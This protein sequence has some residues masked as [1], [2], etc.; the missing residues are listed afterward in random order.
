MATI[1]ELKERTVTETPLLLFECHLSSGAKECWS[2]HPVSVD[3]SSYAARV[4]THNLF[5]MRASSDDGLDS[6]SRVSLTLANADSYFSQIAR[7][8]GLKG[9]R[10]KVTFAFYDLAAGTVS[11]ESRVLFQGV[12]NAPDE[13]TES[14]MR[15]TA[16][17]RFSLLRNFL[18]EVRIQKRCPWSFPTTAEMRQN[19][20][21]GGSRGKYSPLSRCGYSADQPNGVGNFEEGQPY[22]SCDFTRTQCEERGMF[23]RDSAGRTTARFGGVEFVPASILVRGYGEHGFHQSAPVEN[24]TRYND[25]VPLGYGTVWAETPVVFVR[26]DGNLTRMEVLLGMGEVSAVHK[27]LVDD[28]EVPEGVAGASMAHTGWFNLVSAGGASG[29][30]NLDFTD[31]GGRP[32]GDPY[33]SIAFLSVVVPN[34]ISDGR[35]IPTVHVLFDGL[36]VPMY[37]TQGAYVGEFFTNNPAWVLL[38]LLRRSGWTIQEV[39]PA[40]FAIAALHCAEP[41]ASTDLYGNPI[42]I[43]RYQCN[44]HVSRRRSAADLIRG[45]C[46]SAGLFLNYN[47]VGRLELRFE[48]D[49]QRQQPTPPE[50]TNGIEA[51]NGG[52]PAYEFGDGTSP[53]SGILRRGDGSSSV[54]LYHRSAAESVNRLSVEF[55]DEFNEYQQDSLSLIDLD[56]YH[57]TGQEVSGNLQA[58]GIPNFHQAAR[59]LRRQLNKSTRGS[60]FIE[61]ETSVKAIYLRPGDIIT[62]TYQKEGLLRQPFRVT[63][64]TPGVNFQTVRLT[65]QVHDDAWFT[66]DADTGSSVSR[67][68][69]GSVVGLP[70]PLV[71]TSIDENGRQQFDVE[72]EYME[73][74]DGNATLALKVHFQ[75]PSRSART[76]VAIPMLSLASDVDPGGGTLAGGQTLYYAVSGKDSAGNE[77]L[78]SFVVRARIPLGSSSNAV[79]LKN[80]RFSEGTSS[81]NVYRGN[82][83]SQ[84][85]LIAENVSLADQF[86]DAG[87]TE[88]LQGPPDPNFEYARFE[89]RLEQLPETQATISS[90]STIGN[91]DL[92]VAAN[93]FAG[94]IAKIISGR[95]AGQE[96]VIASHDN[97]TFQVVGD[98]SELPDVTS[99]FV[100]VEAAWRPG[101]TS[102]TSPA[103]FVALNRHGATIHVTGRAGNAHGREVGYEISPLTRWRIGGGS[104]GTRD[105]DVPPAPTFGLVATGQGTIEVTGLAFPVF[106]NTRTIQAGTL[107]LHFWDELAGSTAYHLPGTLDMT[108]E[109]VTLN[110][111]GTARPGDLIQMSNEVMEVREVT[112]DGLN[113]QVLRGA[114]DTLPRTH[115]PGAPIYHM[116]RKNYVMAFGRDFFGSPASG[117]YAYMVFLPD[118]RIAAADLYMTNSRGNSQTTK[119]N[120]T[121]TIDDGLRTLAGGQITLQVEGNLAIQTSACPPF[122]VESP[123]SVRDVFAILREAPLGAP[124]D[125]RLRVNDDEYCRLTI[126]TGS[127]MSNVVDGFELSPLQTMARISLD[128][129]SV[130]AGVD[131]APGRDLT[132]TIRL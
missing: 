71:G 109:W 45:V 103:Q 1:I 22:T 93:E 15:V 54:Q 9:A 100:V 87:L 43:P 57:I 42:T 83:P 131:T 7:D 84:M 116:A 58:L 75:V 64:M 105:A 38:D 46:N 121:G 21:D 35:R 122:A 104:G 68:E 86:V 60:L 108:G 118:S 79:R 127:T 56:D 29:G 20:I 107:T 30:F 25:S 33:G 2:T 6:I 78:L 115:V 125:L 82:T 47:N 129:L 69:D 90:S 72:E 18:P 8:P 91:G 113:Y 37:D 73:E 3:D 101:A 59:L 11:S 48:S 110:R 97:D 55:Q 128:V 62:I 63:K 126:P 49:V 14:T 76:R 70:R 61:F 123:H 41:I 102:V 13:I 24:Q 92:N 65:A 66:D 89:W 77:S 120:F 26:N 95:G 28:V 80:L 44:L 117:T 51:L 119:L 106:E 98:W 34:R 17:N 99:R 88:T 50:G 112:L 132:V 5:D 111:P 32:L 10:L 114:Y 23:D 36:K 52:W 40:S 4:L 67:R 96:R 31:S 130:G 12:L 39:D 19:A 27:V 74:A 81:Y 53:F 85:L 94:M 124:V 16:V